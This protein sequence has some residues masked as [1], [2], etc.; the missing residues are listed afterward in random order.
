M[1]AVWR[2]LFGWKA[3]ISRAAATQRESLSDGGYVA[4]SFANRS[5]RV[6]IRY[7]SLSTPHL[8]AARCC[9]SLAIVGNSN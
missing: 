9:A 6:N 8:A 2:R 7:G 3:P 1:S 4:D 5:N